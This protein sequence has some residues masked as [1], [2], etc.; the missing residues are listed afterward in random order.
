LTGAVRRD[1]YARAQERG[2]DTRRT[3]SG[4]P[5]FT[6]ATGA[7]RCSPHTCRPDDRGFARGRDRSSR[8]RRAAA[9]ACLAASSRSTAAA[10]R[11]CQTGPSVLAAE[12]YATVEAA[13][14]HVID[15]YVVEPVTGRKVLIKNEARATVGGRWLASQVE[16]AD[17]DPAVSCTYIAAPFELIVASPPPYEPITSGRAALPAPPAGNAQTLRPRRRGPKPTRKWASKGMGG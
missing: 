15:R 5:A 9:A 17:I 12:S 4:H 14:V 2:S 13:D 8:A 16:V 3:G 10:R 11:R 7:G 1:G 6:P